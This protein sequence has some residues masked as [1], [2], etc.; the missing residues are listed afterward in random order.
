MR[1]SD[2]SS[3]WSKGIL[4]SSTFALPITSNEPPFRLPLTVESICAKK[5]DKTMLCPKSA[6]ANKGERGRS[7]YPI[8]WRGV[9]VGF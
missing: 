5:Y 7:S 4:T 6:K 9:K 3:H 2:M 1:V 8:L